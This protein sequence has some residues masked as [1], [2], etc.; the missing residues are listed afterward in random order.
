M[1]NS[2]IES[3]M[4]ASIVLLPPSLATNAEERRDHYGQS[5]H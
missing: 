1:V 2:V 5:G 3:L 4:L